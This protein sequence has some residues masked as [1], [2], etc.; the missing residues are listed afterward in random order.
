MGVEL[1]AGTGTGMAVV[2]LSYDADAGPKMFLETASLAGGIDVLQAYLDG[3]I[4]R[5]NVQF[6]VVQDNGIQSVLVDHLEKF[7]SPRWRYLVEGTT[8][9]SKNKRDRTL[10][11]GARGAQFNRKAILFPGGEVEGHPLGCGCAWDTL[12][13]GFMTYPKGARDDTVM[14]TFFAEQAIHK[15]G[16]MPGLDLNLGDWTAR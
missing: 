8:T 3:A 7:G 14:A 15:W 2:V 6:I 4:Q 11:V 9:T 12:K 5:H 1:S 10:G 13:R 16:L